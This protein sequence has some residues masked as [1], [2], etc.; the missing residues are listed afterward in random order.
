MTRVSTANSYSAVLANLMRAQQSQFDAQNQVTSEKKATDLR[1]FSQ[2]AEAL[3]AART[4]SVRSDSFIKLS[5]ALKGKLDSQDLSL[6]RAADATL[7]AKSAIGNAIASGNG[8]TLMQSL[9]IQ[10]GAVLEGLNGQHEGEYLFSGSQTSTKPVQV[11]DL[12]ALGAVTVASVFQ[13]DSIVPV[14]RLDET[15]VVTTGFVADAIGT[16]AL[17]A[18]KA[19]QDYVNANG[20]F[21]ST[22]TTAQSDFLTSQLTVFEAAN[23]GLVDKAALNGSIHANVDNSIADQ[24]SRKSAIDNAIVDISG[25]NMADAVTRLQRSQQAVQAAAQ[26]FNT[27]RASSLLNYLN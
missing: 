24:T 13:N 14:S 1:G 4:V 21:G 19:I 17:A 11:A 5:E 23:R 6:N 15:T 16:P 22:L 3:V 8:T 27:L 7:E 18:F 20:T 10:F 12:A 2:D 25:V 9:Q 26:V